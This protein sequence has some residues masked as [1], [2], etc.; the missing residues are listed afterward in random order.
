MTPH[1]AGFIP[2]PLAARYSSVAVAF[3]NKSRLAWSLPP[4]LPSTWELGGANAA[5]IVIRV[6]KASASWPTPRIQSTTIMTE[7]TTTTDE[8]PDEHYQAVLE[9]LAPGTLVQF[10]TSDPSLPTSAEYV[11]DRRWQ[12]STVGLRSSEG[13]HRLRWD[14]NDQ[15][16]L[17]AEGNG[18]FRDRVMV[19]TTIEVIGIASN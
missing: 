10:N 1:T 9:A 2:P 5:D 17:F 7:P 15:L 11:V 13:E 4:Q 6:V 8:S 16:V 14:D 18:W 3:V 12:H 19:V